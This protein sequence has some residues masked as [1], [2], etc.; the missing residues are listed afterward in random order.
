MVVV[1]KRIL[2][3]VVFANKAFYWLQFQTKHLCYC[4]LQKEHFYLLVYICSTSFISSTESYV[5]ST[6]WK[7]YTRDIELTLKSDCFGQNKMQ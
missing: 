4:W 7:H 2:L 6:S 5:K 3:V 1:R